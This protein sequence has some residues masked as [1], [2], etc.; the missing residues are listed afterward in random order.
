VY[1]NVAS[2]DHP[3]HESLVSVTDQAIFTANTCTSQIA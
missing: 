1:L 2:V 3:G